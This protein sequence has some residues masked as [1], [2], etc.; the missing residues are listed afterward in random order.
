LIA[1]QE[2]STKPRRWFARD[3]GCSHALPEKARRA[4]LQIIGAASAALKDGFRMM[5]ASI[6]TGFAAVEQPPLRE[7]MRLV[8][9]PVC[10]VTAGTGEERT[11]ATVTSAHSLALE[12]EVM[13][14]SLNRATSTFPVIEKS[15]HYCV[16]VL[17]LHH[18][19][20]AERFAGIGGLKGAARYAGAAWHALA[21]GALALEGALAAIDCSVEDIIVR[22]THALILGR[23]RAVELGGNAPPLLYR[24]GEYGAFAAAPP[25]AVR[26]PSE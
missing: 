18:Q 21:T 5:R 7:A 6:G 1:S 3:D 26:S 17:A 15:G 23:V 14:I 13:A 16:N 8:A 22:H 10:V 2:R 4:A 24:N 12:P 19:T 11:G 9:G 20:V 25:R